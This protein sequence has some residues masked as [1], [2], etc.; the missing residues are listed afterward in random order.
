MSI[1]LE[2]LILTVGY[3]GLFAIVFAESGLFFGFFFPG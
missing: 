3:A 2:K 1:D